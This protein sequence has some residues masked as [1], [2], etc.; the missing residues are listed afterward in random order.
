MQRPRDT[1]RGA[2]TFFMMSSGGGEREG[3]RLYATPRSPNQ[4]SGGYR[5]LEAG[6]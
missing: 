2:R 1:C 5:G 4:D 3:G 6:E